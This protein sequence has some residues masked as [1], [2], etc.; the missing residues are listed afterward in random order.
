MAGLKSTVSKVIETD[1]LIIGS[2][3]TGSTAAIEA[4]KQGVQVLVVTKGSDIGR[5][6]ATVTGDA[7][8]DVDSRSL[9]ERFRLK[10]ADPNDSKDT[11]F[12]DM[13]KGGKFLNNQKLV[14]VHV[15]NAPDRLADLIEWGCKIDTVVSAS[16]H[17]HNRGVFIPGPYLCPV[18]R[19]QVYAHGVTVM[20]F[21]MVTDLLVNKGRCTGAI[22]LNSKTGELIVFR[23]K[24]T[25]LATGGCMRIYPITTA[26]DELTGDGFGM[27]YRA[28]AELV[29][30]EFPMFLPGGFIW[31]EA[32]KGVDVPFILSTAGIVY[33]Y[34]LNRYG[35]RF[36]A[37]WDPKRMEH[38]TRDIL[39]VAMMTEILEGRGSPHGGVYVSL[40]HLPDNLIRELDKALPKEFYIRYGGFDMKQFLPDLTKEAIEASPAS[41]FFNGGVRIDFQCGTSIPGLFAGGET[42]GGVHGGN[43]LS[44][45]AFTEMVVWGHRAGHYAAKFAK[46]N[47]SPEPDEKKI[48]ELS[49]RIMKPMISKKGIS[50]VQ[51]IKKIQK[52]SWEKLGVIRE[53]SIL[54]AALEEIGQLQKEYDEINVSS[55]NRVLNKEWIQ[56]LQIENMLLT[57]EMIARASLFRKESRAALYRKDF[58]M[59]DN[60]NWLKNIIVK[61]ADGKIS[62]NPQPVVITKLQPPKGIHPYGYLEID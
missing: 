10:G 42:T 16:G 50:P 5:S 20:G 6:G 55:K 4:R 47:G 2:E 37:R 19:K 32:V 17:S 29:D 13:V 44:G 41:H 36:M 60:D 35:E 56:A 53:G 45:N 14:E 62:L 58:P 23:A 7:D 39:S 18:L 1:V 57:M 28:G 54:N 43:R 61:N 49:Q 59:M 34:L 3:G 15:D 38:S 12:K 8:L 26:P 33:A 52:L 46:K 24:S 25:I 22:G 9:H 40:K 21:T 11:F 31:P 48:N 51:L 27:A 30:M